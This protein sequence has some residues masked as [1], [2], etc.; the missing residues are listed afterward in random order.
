MSKHHYIDH[1]K[2]PPLP[3][4]AIRG[5]HSPW[6][7]HN[8][9][10]FHTVHLWEFTNLYVLLRREMWEIF[11]N[12]LK[13]FTLSVISQQLKISPNILSNIRNNPHQTIIV[14]NLQKI[15]LGIGLDL[16]VVEKS[17]QAVRFHRNGELEALSFP[18]N[19]D[20]YAWRLICHI[21]GDGS[22][23]EDKDHVFPKLQWNQLFKHQNHIRA[24]IKRLSRLSGGKSIKVYYPK[25]L[26][27]AIIGTMPGITIQDLGTPKFIQYVFDLPLSYKD[28]KVQFL[29]AFLLDDG[30]VSRTISFTQKD[31]TTLEYIMRLCDQLGYDHSPYPPRVKSP[32]V[33]YF[34][35][36]QAGIEQ[37]HVDL[38][39]CF[40]QDPL[41]GLWH[42]QEKFQL[43]ASSFSLKRG[44]QIR[45]VKEVCIAIIRI[46]GDHQIRNTKELR[47]HPE[48]Y[49]LLEGQNPKKFYKR[50]NYLLKMGLIR[51]VKLKGTS[52]RQKFWAIS[53]SCDPEILIQEFH[54]NYGHRSHPQSRKH[55]FITVTMVEEAKTRLVARGIIP[56]KKATAQEGGFSL[57]V[58]Y[59]RED[60]RK[61]FVNDK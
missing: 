43:L 9:K 14:P 5:F 50:L 11:S 13:G 48:L 32:D 27:Y 40:S 42:K 46:L 41:L 7:S 39:Q 15:C 19:I 59:D 28:W 16:E 2:L 55:N 34:Q 21:I 18:F 44:Y 37:F 23:S 33:H 56:T 4:R 36:R 54:K 38:Y 60:L 8:G 6:S 17:T 45:R 31:K 26:T 57:Q 52:K 22:V 35:L 25:A 49:S 30:S 58:L 53:P 1:R 10:P 12:Y 24:L 47:N 61:L 51:E 29:A 20:I 3:K